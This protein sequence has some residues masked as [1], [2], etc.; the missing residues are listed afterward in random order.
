MNGPDPTVADSLDPTWGEPESLM[1]LAWSKLNQT[2]P[3]ANAAELG[4]DSALKLVP[5]WHYVR[6]ILLPQI[7]E[8]KLKSEPQNVNRC[9]L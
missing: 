8:A 9:H 2:T 4:A 6:D 1:S 7:R 3:D 5:Y